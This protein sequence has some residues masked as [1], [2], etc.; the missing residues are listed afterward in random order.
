[1]RLLRAS[2]ISRCALTLKNAQA[3]WSLGEWPD[4]YEG[5]A[6]P[7]EPADEED[8]SG[9]DT[10]H[11]FEEDEEDLDLDDEELSDLDAT[12]DGYTCSDLG[13]GLELCEEDDEEDEEGD[14]EGQGAGAGS[15][16]GGAWLGFD[17]SGEENH[18]SS[19][20]S[21]GGCQAGAPVDGGLLLAVLILSGLVVSRRRRAAEHTV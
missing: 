1:L 3:I 17:G 4:D 18:A 20:E 5:C 11:D 12:P 2:K 19:V 6:P 15:A 10:G 7:E 9:E 8:E 16:N 13:N 21:V 14:D